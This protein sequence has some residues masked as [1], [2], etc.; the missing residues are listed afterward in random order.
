MKTILLS[1][2]ILLSVITCNESKA[3]DSN[4]VKDNTWYFDNFVKATLPWEIF[5]ETFIGVA[6]QP[7]GDFDLLFYETLYKHKLSETGLCFGMDVLAMK[8]MKYGGYLGYCHPPYAYAGIIAS[9]TSGTGMPSND[10]I[11]PADPN[12]KTAIEIVHGNQINH[13]FLSFVL[14]VLAKSKTRDGGYAYQQVNYFLAKDDPP[15]ISITKSTSPADGGHVVVPF[16]TQDLGSTKRIYVYDPNRSFYK[17]GADGHDFYTKD[18]NYI[19]VSSGGAWTYNMG[20]SL[21]PVYWSGNPGGGGNCVVIPLSI[22]GKK[23]R[24]P[25]SLLAE[26]AYAINTIFLYGNVKV[27]QIADPKSHKRYLNRSGTGIEINKQHRLTSVLPFIP[28]DEDLITKPVNSAEVYFVRGTT[29]LDI[30]YRAIGPYSIRTIFH[31][32]SYHME[33]IGDG[34][35]RHISMAGVIHKKTNYGNK[36]HI[37]PKLRLRSPN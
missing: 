15:V 16:F 32:H 29:P 23:D 10:T 3:Q 6:P 13:G 1:F 25:Q 37:I 5:R 11:G 14:D 2:V 36:I 26:G 27:I 30:A 31:G 8:I 4:W 18:S 17:E 12:L 9:S 22:A 20:K 33:G 28:L 34:S 24:L 21:T 7:S 19:E 35:I